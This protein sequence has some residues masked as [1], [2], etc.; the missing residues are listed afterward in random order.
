MRKCCD[1][2]LVAVQQLVSVPRLTGVLPARPYLGLT[3]LQLLG[4]RAK[5]STYT[6][7]RHLSFP[8]SSFG[9]RL[10]YLLIC[11]GSGL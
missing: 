4:S 3:R 2:F 10:F 9:D 1:L 5:R 6:Y 8:V 7:L 11:F